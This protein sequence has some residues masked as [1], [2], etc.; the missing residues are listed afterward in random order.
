MRRAL[1]FV[2]FVSFTAL[3]NAQE[4]PKY[5]LF[6]G[7][8]YLRQ[9]N[10]NFNGW[11]ASG[12][13][14]FN[15]WIGVKLDADGHYWSDSRSGVFSV[16]LSNHE[17][18]LGPQVSWRQ[19]RFTLFAHTLFGYSR[20]HDHFTEHELPPPF[21][22]PFT[23]TNNA[24]ALGVALGGGGDWNLTEHWAVRAQADYL[25]AAA[26]QDR[27]DNFRFSTGIVYRFGKR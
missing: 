15:H 9:T 20:F 1:V 22:D 8:S 6:G 25:Q 3:V 13:Y 10:T 12:A 14:N 5:E 7:Y 4:T 23:Q 27:S 2:A 18:M 19:K 24:N 16:N 21:P 26:F 11:E 17:I